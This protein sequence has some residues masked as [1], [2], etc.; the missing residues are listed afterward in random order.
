MANG[1]SPEENTHPNFRVR[2]KKKHPSACIF[3]FAQTRS[4]HAKLMQASQSCH[5]V[6]HH[7][8]DHHLQLATQG[9][10]GKQKSDHTACKKNN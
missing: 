2:T 9:W 5:A 4:R 7:G 1:S 10:L 6:S 3:F 8:L